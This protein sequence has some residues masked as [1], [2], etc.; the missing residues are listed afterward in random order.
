MGWKGAW[1]EARYRRYV[2]LAPLQGSGV[3]AGS[4][5]IASRQWIAEISPTPR[6]SGSDHHLV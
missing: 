2:S 1:V 5:A 6:Q 4:I 3:E